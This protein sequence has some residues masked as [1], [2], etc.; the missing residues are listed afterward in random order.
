MQVIYVSKEESTSRGQW[1]PLS[2]LFVM[3]ILDFSHR[4]NIAHSKTKEVCVAFSPQNFHGQKPS[5]TYPYSQEMDKTLPC[6][7]WNVKGSRD[8]AFGHNDL[9]IL[10]TLE[11]N[12]SMNL[13]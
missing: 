10:A 7:I 2:R 9:T 6:Q 5:S 4:A 11:V 1:G 3:A 12:S 13:E 8:E